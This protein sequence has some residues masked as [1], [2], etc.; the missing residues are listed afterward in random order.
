MKKKGILN[1][2]LS[3]LIALMGHGDFLAIVDSGFP[4]KNS[5]CVDL[6][7]VADKPTIIDV[8]SPIVEELEIEK[9]IMAEEIKK[10]SP[11]YHER[12]LKVFPKGIQIEYV[13]HE[14]FKNMVNNEARGVVRTGEQTSYS[15]LILVGGVTYHGEK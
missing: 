13:P 4:V 15:S 11:K 1:R 12:L 10:I 5:S 2:D 3:H 14:K 9:I 8:V 6:S 7:L